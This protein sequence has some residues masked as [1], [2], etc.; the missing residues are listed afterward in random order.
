MVLV[1]LTGVGSPTH[2]GRH[3][4]LARI[5]GSVWKG[6]EQQQAF[7]ALGVLIIYTPDMSE[8][9][10]HTSEWHPHHEGLYCEP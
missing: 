9:L 7:I 5:P 1:I 10:L 4:S 8:Q 6:A 3:H 2:C